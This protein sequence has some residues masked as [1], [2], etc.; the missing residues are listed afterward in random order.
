M[1]NAD[2]DVDNALR[3]ALDILL[4]TPMVQGPIR[5]DEGSGASW[6]FADPD[7]ES[8]TPTQKQLVRMG[9]TN[10]ETLL[11]WLRALRNALQ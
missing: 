1:G 11:V 4:D 9:P 3:N 7:L 5:V 2:R 8:L 6:D 10:T